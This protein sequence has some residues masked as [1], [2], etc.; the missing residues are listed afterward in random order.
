MPAASHAC[1]WRPSGH[2]TL[3]R[4]S[5]LHCLSSSQAAIQLYI[6]SS[7]LVEMKIYTGVSCYFWEC[8][9]QHL[10]C[11]IDCICAPMGLFKRSCHSNDF[12]HDSKLK[13]CANLYKMLINGGLNHLFWECVIWKQFPVYKTAGFYSFPGYNFG[14]SSSVRLR[15]WLIQL[16]A[17]PA[18]NPWNRSHQLCGPVLF[19]E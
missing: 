7:T 18:K 4:D 12:V 13:I 10:S 19:S 3:R 17:T 6:D 1:K 16:L 15:P 2:F 14:F 9:G 8:L 5:S 11:K